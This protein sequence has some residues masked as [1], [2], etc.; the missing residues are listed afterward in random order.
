M[1]NAGSTFQRF[2][3][4][5]F[6]N[7]DNVF[8]YL[9]DILIASDSPEQHA[10]DLNKVLSILSEHNLRLSINKCEFFKNFLTLLGYEISTNGIR[11]PSDRINVISEYPLPKNSFELRRFMGMLNFFRQMIPGFANI[12]LPVTELLRLNPS[13]KQL[14]WT[15]DAITSFNNLKQALASCPTL[16][17]PSIECTEYHLVTDSSNYAV[18][19]A[20]YQMIDS[21]PS[22]V[23]FF[24]R[25]LSLTQRSYSTYDREL[26]GAYLAVLH[27]K[28]IIDGHAVTLFTD[29]KPIVAAIKSQNTPA[30]ERQ[31]RQLSFISEYIK[32]VAYIKGNNNIV[33]DCLSRPVCAMSADIFDLPA[34]ARAQTEDTEITNYKEKLTEFNLTPDLP[35]FC[36]TSTPNPRPFLP[37]QTRLPVIKS[38]HNLSHP[39]VKGTCK[40]VKQR[41]YWPN[42]D[43]DI[44]KFV[45][46]C[47]SCQQSKITR[48]TK[49]PVDPISAPADRFQTVHIDIVGALPTATLPNQSNP[50]PFGT[51]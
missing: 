19:A 7:V 4:S 10:D 3:D 8:I 51:C 17:Y 20:L 29:H 45:S 23:A 49:T 41:Y 13:T 15:D 25:K 38:L 18:G 43:A 30:S 21:N 6:S 35:I 12:A 16:S 14:S 44:Q 42:M 40:L 31:Q 24:S 33:A 46:E 37:V 11:P 27:F 47:T 50:L 36:D 32:T 48:H 9:D 22:P 5:I 26:L 28:S 34:I 1:K 2:M 39:G